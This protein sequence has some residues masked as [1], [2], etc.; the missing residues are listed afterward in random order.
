M[1][2]SAPVEAPARPRFFYGWYIVAAAVVA[3][4]VSSS[5]Q[6]YAGGVFL[7][8]MTHDLGW[9][10]ESFSAVQTVSTVVTGILGLV[11]G[12]MLDRRG[13]RL[14]MTWGSVIAGLSL[15]ATS[16]VQ[17]PWQFYL[18]RGVG[19]SIGLAMI[20]NLV[21]NVT[22]SKWFVARRGMAI[23]IAS[24]GIS[25]GG[26]AMTP[27]AWFI[28]HYGWRDAWV[29]LGVWVWVLMVP[30][31]L[32]MRSAPERYG[33]T[34]D[35][36][37]RDEARA[38]AE[39]NRRPSASSEV[40]WTRAEAIRTRAIWLVMLAYGIAGIG[41]GAMLLHLVPFMTDNGI[42][43]PRAAL[44]FSGFAWSALFVKF[45]WGWMM[46]RFHARYLSVISFTI[47]GVMMVGFLPAASTHN[48]WVMLLMLIVYGTGVGGAVPLQETV[49]ASYFGRQH[50][51][52]IRAVAMP[53][54]IFFG[55]GGPLL[56]GTLYDWSGNYISAFSAFAAFQIVGIALI[57]LARP[58][59]HPSA[60][61]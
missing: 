52:E 4:I 59:K 22:V 27:L 57:L 1:A 53:F 44:L 46:D 60:T 32:V 23:A 58:P 39:R 13:P 48:E 8:P 54:S 25:M 37:S 55:A 50:L 18:I 15:V 41:Y 10:R 38:F 33:L 28:D 9:S 40:Q 36:M 26:V 17:E 19:Q 12:G 49:W 14:L 20:G 2:A 5:T 45:F 42:A 56:A 30:T 16:L 31:I 47:S 24:A 34:P 43:R 29:L 21:V 7:T 6:A 11:I 35:G 51:G 61:T 3:Q